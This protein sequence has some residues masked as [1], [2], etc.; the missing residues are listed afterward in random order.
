MPK[1]TCSLLLLLNIIIIPSAGSGQEASK[2]TP[3]VLPEKKTEP[4]ITFG[5]RG[6]MVVRASPRAPILTVRGDGTFTV[7]ADTKYRTLN[8]AI[9][10][11]ELQDLLHYIIDEQRFFHLDS[12]EMRQGP[13]FK[14]GREVSNVSDALDTVFRIATAEK[15][16]EISFYAL[17]QFARLR[18]DVPLAQHLTAIATRLREFVEGQQRASGRNAIDEAIIPAN[19]FLKREVPEVPSL[20]RDDR[21]G[22]VNSDLEGGQVIRFKINLPNK[23]PSWIQVRYGPGAQEPEVSVREIP[24]GSQGFAAFRQC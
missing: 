15:T 21:Q 12:P 11:T 7:S 23:P 22:C 4:V 2:K 10:Q 20:K 1:L 19:A 9:S 14:N 3:I 6:G 24:A 17:D 18:P 5:Y 13:G 16:S 8:G